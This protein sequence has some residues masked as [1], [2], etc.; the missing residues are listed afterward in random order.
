MSTFPT[1]TL[2][3]ALFPSQ[4]AS[5]P[6]RVSGYEL[7]VRNFEKAARMAARGAAVEDVV[8]QAYDTFAPCMVAPISAA[9]PPRG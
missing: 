5:T 1:S 3:R 8:R 6:R 2:A 9:E 7:G 4:V